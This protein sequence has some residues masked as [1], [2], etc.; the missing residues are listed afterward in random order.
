MVGDSCLGTTAELPVTRPQSAAPG[1]SGGSACW[2]FPIHI[3]LFR[4]GAPAIDNRM[5]PGVDLLLL[6]VNVGT[7]VTQITS[8]ETG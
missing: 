2:I 7:L 1:E 8:N 4:L 3:H 6:P 5:I